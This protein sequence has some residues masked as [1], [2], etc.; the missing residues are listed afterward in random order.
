[1]RRRL[2]AITIAPFSAF[3]STAAFADK[4]CKNIPSK[5]AIEVGGRCDPVKGRWA[6]GKDGASGT[7]SAHNECNSRIV[8]QILKRDKD[9]K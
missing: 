6:V 3:T 1:M 9:K 4:G 2:I 8:V 7:V 5:C